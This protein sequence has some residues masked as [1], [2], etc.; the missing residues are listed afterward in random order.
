ME[1][2]APWS[3]AKKA[4]KNAT[5]T[6]TVLLELESVPEQ[7]NGIKFKWVQAIRSRRP[8]GVPVIV[9]INAILVRDT[10]Y[11]IEN[12]TYSKHMP[13]R[14]GYHFARSVRMVGPAFKRFAG[15]KINDRTITMHERCRVKVKFPTA[16][17]TEFGVKHTKQMEDKLLPCEALAQAILLIGRSCLNDFT[18]EHP[19]GGGGNVSVSSEDDDG[20][21]R[22]SVAPSTAAG[23]D[24]DHSIVASSVSTELADDDTP[25]IPLPPLPA[26]PA[27]PVRDNNNHKSAV[28]ARILAILAAKDLETLEQ[29][30]A[31]LRG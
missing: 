21:G 13:S 29:L 18:K 12:R 11:D 20:T 3:G 26:M 24:D 23:D 8:T 19:A 16:L 28:I 27:A 15:I 5:P 31:T 10:V 9:E 14:S 22:E 6:N 2:D 1:V 7:K 4:T 25:P 30:E 17:D